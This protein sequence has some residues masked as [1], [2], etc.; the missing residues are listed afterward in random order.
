M[1]EI[2]FWTL[3]VLVCIYSGYT[4]K[5]RPILVG[6]ASVASYYVYHAVERQHV[7]DRNEAKQIME[8]KQLAA[9]KEIKVK[10][11]RE[12]DRSRELDIDEQLQ[13]FYMRPS[14]SESRYTEPIEA[15]NMFLRDM[16]IPDHDKYTRYIGEK[17]EFKQYA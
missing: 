10:N 15:R 11:E 14:I 6:L 13:N 4:K 17:E 2:I 16:P 12:K 5:I 1:L 8:V 3:F 7:A 9:Q